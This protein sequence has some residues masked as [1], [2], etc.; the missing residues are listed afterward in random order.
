MTLAQPLLLGCSGD[1]HRE[2]SLE[3]RDQALLLCPQSS[4]PPARTQMLPGQV[5]NWE[6][7]VCK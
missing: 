7:P 5:G 1:A 6:S 2:K 4:A 3:R